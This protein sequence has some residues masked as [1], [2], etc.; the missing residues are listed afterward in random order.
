MLLGLARTAKISQLYC[1][2]PIAE[3]GEILLRSTPLKRK[4][5]LGQGYASSGRY[6][7]LMMY[8]VFG[9]KFQLMAPLGPKFPVMLADRQVVSNFYGSLSTLSLDVLRPPP[10]TTI[11]GGFKEIFEGLETLRKGE[12]RGTKLVVEFQ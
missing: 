8:T 5:G 7:L 9:R 11:K 1:H 6:N 10:A 2:T 4:S 3:V 12:V